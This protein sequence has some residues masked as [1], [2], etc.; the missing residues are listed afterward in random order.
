MY[1]KHKTKYLQTILFEDIQENPEKEIM[2]VLDALKIDSRHVSSAMKALKVYRF[3]IMYEKSIF[4][5]DQ[6]TDLY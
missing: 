4:F 6:N 5:Q 1:R 2:K 3:T